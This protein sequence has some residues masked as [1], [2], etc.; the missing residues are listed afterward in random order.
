MKKTKL[1][2]CFLLHYFLHK[3]SH[4]MMIPSP[5][6]TVDTTFSYLKD[7]TSLL[8]GFNFVMIT[9]SSSLCFLRMKYFHRWNLA[10]RSKQFQNIIL[11]HFYPDLIFLYDCKQFLENSEPT[12][13]LAH[14]KV[15]AA[16]PSASQ[17]GKFNIVKD[18]NGANCNVSSY[19]DIIFLKF[20]KNS[21]LHMN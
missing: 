6:Y 21:L 3:Q 13:T 9:R 10:C 2:V 4:S 12:Q 18:W 1:D 17:G 14:H 11:G 19:T 15:E 20:I 8:M 16:V 7:P 5:C